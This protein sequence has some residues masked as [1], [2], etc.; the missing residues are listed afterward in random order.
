MCV[1][2]LWVAMSCCYN[3]DVCF[4]AGRTEN[5]KLHLNFRINLSTFFSIY[6]EKTLINNFLACYMGLWAVFTAL[7]E[8]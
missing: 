8:Q 7:F 2:L 5:H 6:V 4:E 1:M 3:M